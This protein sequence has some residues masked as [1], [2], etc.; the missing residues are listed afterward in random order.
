MRVT[1]A[2]GQDGLSVDFDAA[3]DVIEPAAA[4]V[5]PPSALPD[6]LRSPIAS[7]PLRDLVRPH[8]RVTLVISDVTRPA[9]NRPLVEAVLHEIDHVPRERISILVATG[10]HRPCRMDELEA[11]LGAAIV[12]GYRVINHDANA[13][14]ELREI[15][16][17][18][19][20]RPVIVNRVYLDADVRITLGLIEPHF[21]AGFSGGAK[22]ILPGVAGAASI[23][24]NHD[25]EMIGHP[26]AR[27]GVRDGNPIM[28]DQRAAARL[29]GCEFSM[30]VLVNARRQITG[31]FAGAL[32]PAHDAGCDA[33]LRTVMQPVA[34]AY[35]VVVTTNGGYPL[36]LNLYQA[37]KGMD[38]AAQIVRAD[39]DIVIAAECREGAGHGDF[40]E[41][42]HGHD[43]PASMLA[44]I[45]SPHHL[46]PDQWQ[47]QILARVLARATVHMHASGLTSDE[48]RGAFCQ[49]CADVA[50]CVTE[51]AANGARVCVLPRGPETVPYLA[52][53]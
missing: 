23:M 51:L 46:T 48:I 5:L 28:R 52:T 3:V 45:E 36:D 16:A 37:V 50:S 2:Y 38:A 14:A 11:M 27:W 29:A 19:S 53:A 44:T 43:D 31:V 33:A 9:P 34:E 8:A 10:L 12:R 21:F 18:S 25:A 22:L 7:P 41:M 1:L 32:E 6:A 20:G 24:R 42:L 40:V 47:N 15:G 4:P 39:G 17:T 49:P 35:D 26:N 30:N 13:D